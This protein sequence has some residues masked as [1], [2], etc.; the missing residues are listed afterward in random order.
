MTCSWVISSGSSIPKCASV[1][2]DHGPPAMTSRRQRYR[3]A[4]HLDIHLAAR[5]AD[6][7]H[8]RAILKLSPVLP[9]HALVGGV[10][11]RGHRDPGVLLV[12]PVDVGREPELGPAAHDVGGVEIL[13]RARPRSSMLDR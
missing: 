10:G 6:A 12:Q 4:V 7:R 2:L 11:A 8:R 3:A 1:R 9:R 13:V 5:G